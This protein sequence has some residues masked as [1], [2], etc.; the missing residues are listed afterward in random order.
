MYKG[1]RFVVL[2]F[3]NPI[4]RV[5]KGNSRMVKM[6]YLYM[7]QRWINLLFKIPIIND[8]EVD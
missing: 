6:S 3:I 1:L 7:Y 4:Q 8:N 2:Y 5:L